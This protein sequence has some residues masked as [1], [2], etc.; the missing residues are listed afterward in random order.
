MPKPRIF[1]PDPPAGEI[2]VCAGGGPPAAGQ[3]VRRTVS[4]GEARRLRLRR[5][6]LRPAS[7]LPG[8]PHPFHHLRRFGI[9]HLDLPPDCRYTISGIK[10]DRKSCYIQNFFFPRSKPYDDK[11]ERF[12]TP[13]P[14]RMVYAVSA[15]LSAPVLCGRKAGALHLRLLGQLPAAGCLHP[16]L[17]IFRGLL[18]YVVPAAHRH[19]YLPFCQ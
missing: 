17:R 19:G 5:S 18:L 3:T 14:L 12:F 9:E 7:A 13:A 16:L 10:M 4:A 2:F 11:A 6:G 1:P 15:G 8:L